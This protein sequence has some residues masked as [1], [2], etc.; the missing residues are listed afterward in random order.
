[1]GPPAE[2]A[3]KERDGRAKPKREAEQDT[4]VLGEGV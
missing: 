1:M 4:S 2:E 3:E